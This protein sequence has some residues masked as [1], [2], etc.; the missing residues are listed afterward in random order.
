MGRHL[1]SRGVDCVAALYE[2]SF[3]PDFAGAGIPVVQNYVWPQRR[4]API[5]WE[6]RPVHGLG[7]VLGNLGFCDRGALRAMLGHYDGLFSLARPDIV[8]ADNAF[9]ALLAAR[10]RC[11][12]IALGTNA[13]LPPV[14]GDGFAPQPGAAGPPSWPEAALCDAIGRALEEAG[15]PALS[16]LSDILDVAAVFPFGPPEFDLYGAVRQAPALPPH[17]PDLDGPVTPGGGGEELFVYLHDFVQHSRPLMDALH[18]VER[19]MR[20]H[21]PGLA[22]GERERF[23]P[24]CWVEEEAVPVDRILRHARAVLHHGGLHLASICLAAGLPQV[25]LAKEL[26]NELSGRLVQQRGLGHATLL[27]K[28]TPEWLVASARRV[29][30]DDEL[31]RRCVDAAPE[32]GRWLDRDPTLVVASAA[33]DALGLAG[34]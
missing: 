2:P 24:W 28:A 30:D 9:G 32:F 33:M 10:G 15:R 19:P 26:D 21:I 1:A 25:I 7:D 3:A 16:Q 17:V 22:A 13:C 23:P 20:I 14:L 34:R 8:L 18:A 31:R 5:A 12:A 29:F 27:G 11:P 6:E 4:R